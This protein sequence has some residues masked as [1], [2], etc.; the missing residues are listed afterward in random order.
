MKVIIIDFSLFNGINMMHATHYYVGGRRVR[1]ND[2]YIH[3]QYIHDNYEWVGTRQWTDTNKN[4]V[5][6]DYTEI[7]YREKPRKQLDSWC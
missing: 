5:R 1:A 7:L 6:R 4:G 2:Y 3:N